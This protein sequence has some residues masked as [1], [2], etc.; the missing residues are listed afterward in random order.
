M[1][2]SITIYECSHCENRYDDY[3]SACECEDLPVP[4]PPY[5]V[6]D[7]ISFLNISSMG[8]DRECRS[9]DSRK[10]EH[11]FLRRVDTPHGP[12]HRW[13][14]AV[15]NVEPW[16]QEAKD[17]ALQ[18]SAEEN[19][20]EPSSVAVENIEMYSSG[21]VRLVHW[22]APDELQDDYLDGYISPS[23]EVY[24]GSFM[25]SLR[26]ERPVPEEYV[27]KSVYSELLERGVKEYD[28]FVDG[29]SGMPFEQDFNG[30]PAD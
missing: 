13:V 20:G 28:I 6:G 11:I 23:Q 7:T 22:F 16:E 24:G 8:V 30:S 29:L 14:Y 3:E 17:F 9:T 15:W 2:K 21:S 18:R 25:S 5:N 10:V 1:P 19:G 26:E 12:E 4:I 27:G